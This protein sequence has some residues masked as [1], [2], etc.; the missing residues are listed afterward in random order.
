MG[1]GGWHGGRGRS[2]VGR[3]AAQPKAQTFDQFAA[4]RGGIPEPDH[5]F[6]RG[7]A[8]VSNRQIKAQDQRYIQEVKTKYDRLA[9]LKTQ[10][11]QAV[12]SGAVREPTHFENLVRA[13]Q[14]HPDNPA[15]QAAQR[16]LA[17]YKAR[18]F[19]G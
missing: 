6:I 9:E 12:A 1:R 3:K 7:R 10:Y 4:E 2:G 15:T 18:G 13:S 14:G 5:S 16:L 19:N 8:N 11:K 17:K